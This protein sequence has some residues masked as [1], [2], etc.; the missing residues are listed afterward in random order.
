LNSKL[1]SAKRVILSILVSGLLAVTG[2]FSLARTE[3]VQRK[4]VLGGDLTTEAGP[5]SAAVAGV[6]IGVR[7]PRLASYLDSPLLVVRHGPHQVRYSEY[8]R[9]GEQ[10]GDG[11]NR[12]LAGY[13]S[14]GSPFRAVDVAPWPPREEYDYLIQLHVERFE[15]LA[16]EEPSVAAGEVHMLATWEIVRQR[17]GTVLARGATEHRERGWVVGDY[18]GMVRSLDA[19]LNI[20]S[21]ELA[22]GLAALVSE[23]AALPGGNG[24][25]R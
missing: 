14:A 19:G 25:P 12:A 6:T 18:A 24:A 11:V 15:G 22:A 21:G 16:P 9:W 1:T 17:D 10:L 13:L 5:R 4:Y 3:P 8:H 2:C 7:R 23:T 20:L